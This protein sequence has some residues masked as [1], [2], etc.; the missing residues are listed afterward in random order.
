M[1]GSDEKPTSKQEAFLAALLTAPTLAEAAKAAKIG[2]STARRW[3]TLPTVQS[4]WLDM[5]RQV[6]DQAL[7]TVQNATAEAVATLRGCLA[8]DMPPGVRVRAATAILDTAIRTVEISDLAARIEQ[9]EQALEEQ[10]ETQ[11]RQ[12]QGVRRYA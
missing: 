8:D 4:A 10:R 9:I 7:L 11:Q 2:E 6:V 12:G 5:R 1:S 3:L